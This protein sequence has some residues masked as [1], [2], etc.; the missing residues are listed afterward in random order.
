[1]SASA[2]SPRPRSRRIRVRIA[3][4]VALGLWACYGDQHCY[5]LEE[6]TPT[7]TGRWIGL[8]TVGIVP[9]VWRFELTESTGGLVTGTVTMQAS[10]QT[11]SGTVDGRHSFPQVT[12]DLDFTGDGRMEA[13][14]YNGHL[15]S[16]EDDSNTI[17]GE[18][19]LGD[20]PVRTLNLVRGP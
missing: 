10:Q 7:I 6:P 13:G 2:G 1:M 16:T 11:W 19:E 14:V 17:R 15:E 4:A 12:L 9:E 20:D 3:L 5:Y 8:T 18:L